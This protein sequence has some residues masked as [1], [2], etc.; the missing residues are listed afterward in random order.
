MTNVRKG[1]KKKSLSS[2]MARQ[3]LLAGT[4]IGGDGLK[5]VAF[6]IT[7]RNRVE[8]LSL[9]EQRGSITP[10]TNVKAISQGPTNF[11]GLRYGTRCRRGRKQLLCGQ[12]GI[13]LWQ[14]MYGGLA[15]RL[16]P[17]L[18]NVSSASLILVSRSSINYGI[19]F[20]REGLGD[21]SCLSCMSC[22]GLGP[23]IGNKLCLG[24]GS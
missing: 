3:P 9:K 20:K 24:R 12:F 11:I 2:I 15:S 18:N 21:G 8:T 19:A 5:G 13:K 4:W 16:L 22:V 14:S 10:W 1:K 7:P 17:S 6:L 23:A